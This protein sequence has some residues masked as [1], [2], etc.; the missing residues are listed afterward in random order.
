[1][2]DTN[3]AVHPHTCMA[4]G[5]QFRIQEKNECLYQCSENKDLAAHSCSVLFFL[6]IQKVG[7]SLIFKKGHYE[8]MT[9][10]YTMQYTAIYNDFKNDNFQMKKKVIFFLFLLKS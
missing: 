2:T 3:R 1:M 8:I 7:F 10:Q 6:Y 9:M 5:F 4:R